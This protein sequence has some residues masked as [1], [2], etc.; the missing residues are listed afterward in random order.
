MATEQQVNSLGSKFSYTSLIWAINLA[1]S[2][3]KF[4][5][6]THTAN[7]IRGFLVAQTGL[8]AST[9]SLADSGYY[10]IEWSDWLKFINDPITD[11]VK[12]Y[13]ADVYDCE[14]FA[15]WF[16]TFS[17]LILGT[18]TGGGSFGG[19]YDPY[20]TP[21]K[22]LFGHGFNMIICTEGGK[23]AL[24]LFEPQTKQF[25]NW[26]V[27]KDNILPTQST[28]DWKYTCSWLIYF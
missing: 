24:K 18:N 3:Y 4:T 2:I 17:N 21:Q 6:T 11:K 25:K 19:I 9:I 16:T 7:D 15:F 8:P 13:V 26:E 10:T 22:L 14:N 12:A 28:Q 1:Q 27:G 20:S 23:L 5:Y